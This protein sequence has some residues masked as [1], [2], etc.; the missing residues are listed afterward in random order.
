MIF[1]F[2]RSCFITFI[3]HQIYRCSATLTLNLLA[4]RFQFTTFS[5]ATLASAFLLLLQRNSRATS[6]SF[7]CRPLKKKKNDDSIT[8]TNYCWPCINNLTRGAPLISIVLSLAHLYDCWW[9]CA[10]F[11]RY[12]LRKMLIAPAPLASPAAP[13]LLS[14]TWTTKVWCVL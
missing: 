3:T 1:S 7:V 9:W 5:Q 11:F 13:S 14:C 4:G 6:T 8:K 10:V 12:I 2:L